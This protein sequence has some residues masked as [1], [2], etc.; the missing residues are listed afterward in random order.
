MAQAL[1]KDNTCAFFVEGFKITVQ[2]KLL[3]LTC[4]IGKTR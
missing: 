1:S 4:R 2:D 3:L